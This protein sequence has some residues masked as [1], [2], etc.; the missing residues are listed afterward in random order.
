ML[1]GLSTLCEVQH[2][3]PSN[4]IRLLTRA[5]LG[6]YTHGYGLAQ[7]KEGARISHGT[8]IKTVFTA[9]RAREHTHADSCAAAAARKSSVPTELTAGE[10]SGAVCRWAVAAD[11]PRRS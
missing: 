4:G 1:Y 9:V 3:H 5:E 10:W 6:I 8:C 7:Y 11:R 2:Q